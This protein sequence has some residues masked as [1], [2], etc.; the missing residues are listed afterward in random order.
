MTRAAAHVSVE[1]YLALDVGDV[2]HEYVGGVVHAM[3]GGTPEHGALAANVIRHL[4]TV[5]R[6]R[7][8]QIYTSDVR[9]AIEATGLRTY[10]DVT[11]VCGAVQR[12]DKDVSVVNPTVLVEV[13]SDSTA[14]W[15]RGGKFAHYRQIPSLREYLVVNHRE[16]LVEHHSRG[17][18]DIWTLRDVRADGVI[19]LASLSCTLPLPEVYLKV[20]LLV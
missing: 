2:K 14:D 6:D 5:L 7:P 4:G 15:D 1:E 16:R 10:P 19:E 20:D 3:A 8:C 11:I 12:G 13:T 9:V 17:A 18:G